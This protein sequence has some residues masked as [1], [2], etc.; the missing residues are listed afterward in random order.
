[1]LNREYS[2][3]NLCSRYTHMRMLIKENYLLRV[4]LEFFKS[5]SLGVLYIL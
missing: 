5:I 2:R 3:E 1:M 4:S